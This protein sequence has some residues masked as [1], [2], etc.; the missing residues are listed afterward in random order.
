MAK[1]DKDFKDTSLET[2]LK[3]AEEAD[4]LEPSVA[5]AAEKKNERDEKARKVFKH[6]TDI[7][8][9]EDVPMNLRAILGGDILAGRA[10]RR[11]I[12]YVLMISV[13]A[14]I[15][16]SCRY[17]CQRE[18]ILGRELDKKIEDIEFKVLTA[19]SELTELQKRS[20]VEEALPDTTLHIMGG[21][22]FT[23]P[24]KSAQ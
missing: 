10:F 18:I 15:Y 20:Y 12:G 7:D 19:N 8:A 5:T 24:V 3:R 6:L 11:Q 2:L 9:E 13:M 16:V 4:N 21:R 1:N 22:A 23:M 17:S 14:I